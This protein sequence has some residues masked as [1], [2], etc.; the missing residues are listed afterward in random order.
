MNILTSI[1]Q[2]LKH[3]FGTFFDNMEEF[4][5][6]DT[7][8]LIQGIL[9]A[10]S[11]ISSIAKDEL[12]S[13]SHST[14]TRFVNGHDEFWK[15]LKNKTSA[16]I[17]KSTQNKSLLLVVDDTQVPRRGKHIPFTV[18]SY[19]HCSGRFQ[20]SQVVLT[21]GVVVNG[22]FFPID[23]LFSNVKGGVGIQ[24]M[25]KNDQ[26]IQW[27]KKKS[28]EVEG[29]TLIGDSWFTHS[30][31]AESAVMRFKMNF[32]GRIRSNFKF[33]MDSSMLSVGEYQRNVDMNEA[34]EVEIDGKK[35]RVHER[36]SYIAPLKNWTR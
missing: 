26:L 1:R 22:S 7:L 13:L 19:D 3:H 15:S 18:K 29:A 31:V 12:T 6:E 32:I 17:F 21:I 24:Q 35:I 16:D 8:A 9:S 23:M 14:L 34:Q 25:T 10:H 4:Y 27:L 36:I 28:K 33:R 11:S 2:F 30:Y 5:L 20:N